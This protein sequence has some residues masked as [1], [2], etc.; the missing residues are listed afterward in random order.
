MASD[1]EQESPLDLHAYEEYWMLQYDIFRTR[2]YILRDR[3]KPGEVKN[4]LNGRLGLTK[5]EVQ[6]RGLC[7]YP[8]RR[9]S[10]HAR[11]C[12]H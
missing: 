2:G 1:Q 5:H 10:V 11:F 8:V 7:E 9:T 4:W 6:K 3:Y 12:Q